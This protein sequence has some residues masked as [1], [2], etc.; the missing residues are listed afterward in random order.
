MK[1]L[2]QA[3]DAIN[4]SPN[5]I[6]GCSPVCLMK[7][8]YVDGNIIPDDQLLRLRRD[9]LFNSMEY[10]KRLNAKLKMPNFRI[11][12]WV[13]LVDFKVFTNLGL[14]LKPRWQGPFK[15][16]SRHSKHRWGVW[17]PQKGRF[18]EV[19][20]HVDFMKPVC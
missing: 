2:P 5:R 8:R 7:G 13:W 19:I 6:T 10:R 15:L 14:K 1:V 4:H 17:M 18:Q 16:I 12:Q 11:G 3:V 9:A 20:H